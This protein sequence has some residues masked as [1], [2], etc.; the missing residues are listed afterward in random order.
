MLIHANSA[1]GRL[2][3]TVIHVPTARVVKACIWVD[4]DNLT[5]AVWTH[6]H[7]PG[8]LCEE[9][10]RAKRD[11]RIMED[12]LLILIDPVEDDAPVESLEGEMTPGTPNFEAWVN[13]D[14]LY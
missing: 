9:I 3:W 1:K 12:R 4:D 14:K 7:G 5:W 8:F 13:E 2:G 6:R 11:I 10:F